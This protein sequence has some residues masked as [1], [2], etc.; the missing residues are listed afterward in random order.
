MT[1]PY[2]EHWGDLSQEWGLK[3][4]LVLMRVLASQTYRRLW[5]VLLGLGHTVGRGTWKRNGRS[6][7]LPTP[8]P[9]P[10]QG[11]QQDSVAEL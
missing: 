3:G 8:R 9:L 10:L 6:D 7:A 2:G 5:G 11:H 4:C 1:T